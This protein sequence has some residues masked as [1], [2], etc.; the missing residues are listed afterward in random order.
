M[1]VKK[2][3][4][5]LDSE[6]IRYV[7]VIHSAAY[8]A[9]EIAALTHVPGGQLAK[10]IIVKLDG[11]MAMAVLDASH[12]VDLE[13]LETVAGAKTVELAT[14]EEFGQLFPECQLGAMPP[15]GNLFGMEV[16]VDEGLAGQTEIAFNA[17]SHTELIRLAFAD[18]ERLVTPPRAAFAADLATAT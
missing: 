3:K 14:E 9:Q 7:S 17:G 13:R 1:P 10:S 18:F 8:T 16:Y 6:K 11:K 15:F 12:F 4:E 2:L 5:L